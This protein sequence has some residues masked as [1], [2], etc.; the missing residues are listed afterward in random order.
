MRTHRIDEEHTWVTKK[1]KQSYIL[2][3]FE[4]EKKKPLSDMINDWIKY[5]TR[6]KN[7]KT[8]QVK[9]WN[10]TKIVVFLWLENKLRFYFVCLF[11]NNVIKI[12]I[13]WNWIAIR[14]HT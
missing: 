11:S 2:F 10:E 5:F 6:M 8:R 14:M 12:S 3:S 1:K 7:K 9:S 4:A 13:N